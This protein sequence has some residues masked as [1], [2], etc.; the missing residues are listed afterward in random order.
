LDQTS[1]CGAA[2]SRTHSLAWELRYESPQP[3][4]LLLPA[5]LY[6]RSFPKAKALVGSPGAVFSGA[7]T[8]D[9]DSI[10]VD[11]WTGSQNHNWGSRHTDAYAWGQVAGFDGAPDAFLECSTAQLRLGPVWTPRMSLVVFRANGEEHALT[12]LAQALKARGHFTFFDW[13]IA[14]V[15]AGTR[16]SI[17]ITAPRS[18]FVALRYANPPGGAKTCLNTKLASCELSLQRQ[19]RAPETF[20]TRHRAAFEILTDRNDHGVAVEV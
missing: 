18:D 1:L 20:V 16:V 13:R 17:R 2:S 4:L 9:G 14:S 19:G 11:S 8:L 3:P 15:S 7:I 6:G 5:A 10:S 12:S